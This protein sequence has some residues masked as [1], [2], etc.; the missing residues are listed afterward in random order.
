MSAATLLGVRTVEHLAYPD[1]G[2][3]KLPVDRLA[4]HVARLADR[5]SA[6]GLLAFDRSGVTGHPDH[7]Q[8]TAAAQAAAA[9]LGRP[10]LGWTLPAAIAET[11]NR[12]YLTG[13]AGH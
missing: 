9:Q 1:S 6:V 13:F 3:A 10:M 11:L 8:A 5:T 2:L 4:G 7:R 12:E